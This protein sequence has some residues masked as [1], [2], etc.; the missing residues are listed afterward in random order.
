MAAV[1]PRLLAR[2]RDSDYLELVASIQDDSFYYLLPAFN[3][4]SKLFFTFDGHSPSY[5]FQPAYELLLATYAVFFRDFES[6]LRGA[7]TVG[8]LLHALTSVLIA[9]FVLRAVDAHS[10]RLRWVQYG[11]CIGAGLFYFTRGTVLFSAMTC[12]ENALASA[13]FAALLLVVTV[14]AS[15]GRHRRGL[16]MLV[17]VGIAALLLCRI[18]PTTLALSGLLGLTALLRWKKPVHLLA[19]LA[20][21]VVLWSA[22]ATIAFGHI[23]PTSARVKA[24][25]DADTITWNIVSTEGLTYLKAA[26]TFAMG[27]PGN[28][29]VP[30]RDVSILVTESSLKPLWLVLGALAV[31]VVAVA[32]THC[33]LRLWRERPNSVD[34]ASLV[35]PL[36]AGLT[37]A[38]LAAY[39]AQ[40]TLIAVRRPNELF[41]Y[42]WYL[43]DLP[44]LV[45]VSLGLASI[46]GL[47][48]LGSSLRELRATPARMRTVAHRAGLGAIMLFFSMA[49]LVA[50]VPLEYSKLWGLRPFASFDASADDW[51]HTMMR[52]GLWLKEHEQLRPGDRVA[53]FSCGALGVLFGERVLN[54]DGLANDEAA[55]YWLTRPPTIDQYV[56][57]ARPRYYIDINVSAV[58]ENPRVQVEKLHVLPF[59]YTEG[60]VVAELRYPAP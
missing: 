41:Y 27:Q 20:V 32:G 3:F 38:I 26:F 34:G 43:Y 5:G 25:G 36:A 11:A 35:I 39:V 16:S 30:Q 4:K 55:P 22:Y 18:L 29:W 24:L 56:S 40:G 57:R 10:P 8:V 9:L 53:C 14:R 13:L 23:V 28:M 45:A 51:Q 2:I 37:M 31:V 44:V 47:T 21:P 42:I 33:V 60:Y 17:G 7:M 49:V 50:L 59:A 48:M 58:T 6:F 52:A 54:L 15:T 19:A 1:F 12:K 46:Y